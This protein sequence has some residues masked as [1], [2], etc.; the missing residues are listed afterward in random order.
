MAAAAK[1]KRQGLNACPYCGSHAL[2]KVVGYQDS[3]PV[4]PK[5]QVLLVSCFNCKRGLY[6]ETQKTP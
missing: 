2:R 6:C 1:T 5:R 3:A 4:F